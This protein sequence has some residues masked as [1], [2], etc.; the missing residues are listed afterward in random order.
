MFDGLKD[1]KLFLVNNELKNFDIR[2]KE[3]FKLFMIL[4]S[5][6]KI[7]MCVFTDLSKI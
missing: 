3:N 5:I 2:L 4:N 7:D 1:K 6:Q